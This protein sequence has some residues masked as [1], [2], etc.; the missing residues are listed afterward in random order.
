MLLSVAMSASSAFC[1]VQPNITINVVLWST[2]A[3][4]FGCGVG[5]GVAKL[6]GA[7]TFSAAF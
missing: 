3:A 7:T 4:F 5:V 6:T 2:F 1:S